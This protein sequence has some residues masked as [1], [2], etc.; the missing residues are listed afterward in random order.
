MATQ[1]CPVVLCFCINAI[2]NN[3]YELARAPE[4]AAPSLRSGSLL[5]GRAL[6]PMPLRTTGLAPGGWGSSVLSKTPISFLSQPNPEVCRWL[7]FLQTKK[8]DNALSTIISAR[9]PRAMVRWVVDYLLCVASA[10]L[11]AG[12]DIRY[13]YR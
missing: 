5:R 12:H 11:S 8:K 2:V 7:D 4:K 13:R 9:I 10:A 3:H 6:D 1:Y